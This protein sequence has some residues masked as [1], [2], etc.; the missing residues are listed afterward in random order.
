MP[1]PEELKQK[2]L[3]RLH[4]E[5]YRTEP[6]D[7]ETAIGAKLRAE[8]IRARLLRPVDV[9]QLEDPGWLI[10]RYITAGGLATIFGR[11]GSYKTF[12][13]LDWA[14]SVATGTWWNRRPVAQGPVL[15][16]MAEGV[17]GLRRRKQ[18]WETHHRVHLD[19]FP[20]YWYPQTVN[21][22][23][24]EWAEGLAQV[25]G[26]L[27]C[28][29]VVIDTVARA[30]PGGDENTSRDMGKL[31]AAADLT[32]TTTGGAVILVHHTPLDGG[33]LRGHSSLEGAV[34]TNIG[35]DSDGTT[36]KV[37]VDKQKDAEPPDPLHLHPEPAGESIVLAPGSAP[38]DGLPPAPLEMLAALA[39]IDL[40]AGV[41]NS[42]WISAKTGVALRTGQRHIKRLLEAGYCHMV[43]GQPGDRGA[44]YGISDQGKEAL[45]R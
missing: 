38:G 35:V 45:N 3:R 43:S 42:Q 1:S 18:A 13:A 5:R 7:E 14:C 40:G 34:D 29:L 22:L 37:T 31:I 2:A 12:L 23:D 19:E 41:T 6:G 8:A 9:D 10:E 11:P 44:R 15:Y 20:L 28:R 32:R 36:V 24:D 16:V 4:P 33:R 39:D 26:D 17:G 21:L 30:M 27:G 25:A